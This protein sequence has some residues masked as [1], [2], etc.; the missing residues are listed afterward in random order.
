MRPVR[1][2]DAK[3]KALLREPWCVIECGRR[4]VDPH[5]VVFKS[6]G[7]DDVAANLVGLCRPCHD[8]ITDEDRIVQ[9]SLGEYV[10]EHRWDTIGYLQEMFG[11]QW[12]DWMLRR[13]NIRGLDTARR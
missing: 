4:T 5:H 12:R 1:D 10:L 9:H 7:G 6:Q 11:E 8:L 3:R 13:L 2:P